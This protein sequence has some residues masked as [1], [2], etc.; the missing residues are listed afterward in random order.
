M[1][2]DKEL[3]IIQ[4]LTEKQKNERINLDP[5]PP[6]A[7]CGECGLKILKVMGYSCPN[8]NCPVWPKAM[9]GR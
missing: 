1:T 5:N 8:I 6:V 9:L 3:P 2:T 7:Q 4:P